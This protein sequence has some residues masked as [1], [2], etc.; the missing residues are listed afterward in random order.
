MAQFAALPT[1]GSA[2]AGRAAGA[3]G[4][5]FTVLLLV[6]AGMA[7]VPGGGDQS[8]VIR[9]FYTAHPGVIVT[10]QVVGLI[11]AAAFV[12]F[13]LNLRLRSREVPSR[14]GGVEAA[15][16]AVA[17][18]A[19]LTAVP[20]LWLVVVVGGASD[21]FLHV[22]A[23]ASDLA[24][25]ILFVAIAAFSGLLAI[26]ARPPW[27]RV[28]AA[29]VAVLAAARG[30]ALL[31]GSGTLELVA[32]MSFIGLVVLASTLVLVRRSPVTPR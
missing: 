7:S 16:L 21:R 6:S 3:W 5:A 8:S 1:S 30:V 31:V 32:P 23:V 15:G 17:V 27:F 11:A 24:D 9:R 26:A 14:L 12:P 28:V 22:L 13:V 20:V 25:V 29:L 2:R 19:A 10:A 18:A 4:W